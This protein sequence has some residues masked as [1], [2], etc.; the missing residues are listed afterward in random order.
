MVI[1]DSKDLPDQ[2][3][4][5]LIIDT[6]KNFKSIEVLAE[7]SNFKPASHSAILSVDNAIGRYIG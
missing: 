6:K 4:L 3:V 1:T 7:V 2:T 5:Y